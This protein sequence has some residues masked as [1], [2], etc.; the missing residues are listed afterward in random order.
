MGALYPL[1]GN[2]DD[3]KLLCDEG[4]AKQQWKGYECSKP[5]HLAKGIHLT[6]AVITKTYEHG[7]GHLT[8][9]ALYEREALEVPLVCLIIVA[10]LTLGK[11]VAKQNVQNV[12]VD[13][14]NNGGGE[15]LAG[16][17]EH[18]HGWA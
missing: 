1:V 16:E 5:H 18:A 15:N 3:D 10:S 12:V 14:G 17:T 13:V 8:Y 9:H 7:L 2:G 4:K 11:Q 6:P